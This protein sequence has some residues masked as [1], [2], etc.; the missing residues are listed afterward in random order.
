MSRPNISLQYWKLF[1]TVQSAWKKSGIDEFQDK[2]TA[3]RIIND[4]IDFY[5]TTYPAS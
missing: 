2:E 4:A 5:K 1:W 3:Y